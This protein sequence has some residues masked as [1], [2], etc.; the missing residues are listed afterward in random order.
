MAVATPDTRRRLRAA[1]A[2]AA[3]TDAE[4][5]QRP[6]QDRTLGITVAELAER[7][8]DEWVVGERTLGRIERGECGVEAMELRAIARACGLPYEFFTAA[9]GELATPPA[10]GA[11]LQPPGELGRDAQAPPPTEKPQPQS[12]TQPERDDEIGTGE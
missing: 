7:L 4:L 10:A 11:P 3:P 5:A 6:D 1:R 12:E 8:S 9:L 2:L